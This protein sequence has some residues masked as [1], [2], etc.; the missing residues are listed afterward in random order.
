[1]EIKEAIEIFEKYG[2]KTSVDSNNLITIS[3]YAQPREKTF[4]ELGINEDE[5]IENVVACAGVFDARKSK[6]TTFPLSASK[7][8]RLYEDN[9]ISEMPE[10]RAAG[11]FV[12]NKKLKKLPKLKFVS[13]IQ[14]E[15]SPIK[16]LPKLKQ[17]GI[18]IAQNS[19]LKE[20]P[21]LE[22]VARLCI[23]D[24]PLEDLKNLKYA[25]DIFLCSSDENNKIDI[26]SL[27]KLEEVEKLFVANSTLKSIPQL[28]KANKIGLYNCAI[29]SIKQSL[30]AE[31]E[32]ANK[33]TDEELSEKF[34]NFTDWYNSDVLQKS[35]DILGD[36]VN[37]IN[38]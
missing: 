16:T 9:E 28:K 29:K 36:I 21:M 20:L 15:D 35:M 10:L 27:S 6:L 2:I 37:K 38:S 4:F 1:M 26:Q 23:V 31:V 19:Q 33:I 25:G 11:L 22:T 13:S 17:A 34:D 8:I 7:E 14:L 12:V 30:G 32:I 3:H 18:L 5:L 24:C